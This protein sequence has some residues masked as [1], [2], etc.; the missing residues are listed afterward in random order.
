MPPET[1][2]KDKRLFTKT[3][4]DARL[5][6]RDAQYELGLMYANGIGTAQDFEQAISWIRQAAEKGLPAAQYL[7]ASRYNTGDTVA[8]DELEACRW[9]LKAVDQGHAKA[10]YRLARFLSVAH[11]RSAHSLFVKA[12]ELGVPDAQYALATESTLD[13]DDTPGQKAAFVWCKRAA[14][15]GMAAAQCALADRYVRGFGVEPNMDQA[16]V[17]YRKAAR[18]DHLPAQLALAMLDDSGVGRGNAAKKWRRKTNAPDRRQQ[19]DRWIAVAEVGDAESKHCLGM[20]FEHGWMVEPDRDQAIHWYELAAESNFCSAQLALASMLETD[21]VDDQAAYWYQRASAQSPDVAV[22]ISRMYWQRRIPDMEMADAIR[23]TMAAAECGDATALMALWGVFKSGED[24]FALGCLRQ[25]AAAGLSE[26]QFQ[27][28][29][30]QEDESGA[31]SALDLLRLAAKQG[32]MLAQ[33][34]LGALLLGESSLSEVKE[35]QIWL[36]KA[37]EQGDSKAQWLLSQLLLTGSREVKKDLRLAFTWCQKAAESGFAPAQALFGLLHVRI[38]KPKEAVRWWLK[39]AEQG[40]PEAQFNLATALTTGVGVQPNSDQAFEWFLKAA[41]QGILP[42]Q[43]KVGLLYATGDGVGVDL[44]EA[45]KW[46]AIAR[47]RGDKTAMVNG[48]KS[49]AVLSVAQ[50]K[51]GLRRATAWTDR[52]HAGLPAS[53]L[54]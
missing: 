54:G 31:L 6:M 21:R 1:L 24:G 44:I 40:D 49:E 30:I 47:R 16:V 19:I 42:A 29:L 17:W 39:A 28:A 3:L 2:T 33:S 36:Q 34:H 8:Q 9:F 48:K 37:A 15:Q 18:Q 43:A 53:R 12:A 7:L 27:L 45:F 46:F 51:E 20:M 25:A 22:A 52:Y 50:V 26:A 11:T 4:K 41:C 13:P 10:T 38:K 35:A 23:W 32:H 5:G 14:E